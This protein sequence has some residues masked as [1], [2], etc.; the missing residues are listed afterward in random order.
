LQ[1]HSS[2]RGRGSGGRGGGDRD[3]NDNGVTVGVGCGDCDV[4]NS[5]HRFDVDVK[6][7]CNGARA[8]GSDDVDGDD[9]GGDFIVGA[10]ASLS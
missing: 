4:V 2:K 7:R 1:Q 8:V 9:G 10:I 3:V 6:W 5:I